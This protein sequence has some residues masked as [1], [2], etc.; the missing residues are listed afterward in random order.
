MENSKSQTELTELE[1]D[2]K[3]KNLMDDNTVKKDN[4]NKS[5]EEK[6]IVASK[7]NLETAKE[8]N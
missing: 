4:I 6:K 8:V 3:S 5:G 7:E 2:E 1:R